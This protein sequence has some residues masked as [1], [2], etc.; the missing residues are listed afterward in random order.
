MF[1]KKHTFPI[2]M[3]NIIVVINYEFTVKSKDIKIKK[4]NKKDSPPLPPKR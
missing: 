3:T 2:V 4:T 1:T